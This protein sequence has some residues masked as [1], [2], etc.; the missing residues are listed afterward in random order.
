MWMHGWVTEC[1][2]SALT[3]LKQFSQ[4]LVPIYTPTSIGESLHI[5]TN[6]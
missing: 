3:E 5:L 6:P 4:G 1:T 2:C